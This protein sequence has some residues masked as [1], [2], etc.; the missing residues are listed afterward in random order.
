MHAYY[1]ETINVCNKAKLDNPNG[2]FNCY[3]HW[4]FAL[5][6]KGE[7]AKAVKKIKKAISTDPSDADNWVV[8]GLILRTVG[9]IDSARHKFETALK[10][11][12]ENETAI[13]EL[14]VLSKIEVLNSTIDSDQVPAIKAMV[15]RQKGEPLG[16]DRKKSVCKVVCGAVCTTF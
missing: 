15:A 4:A 16:P 10:I 14:D 3:R 12:P 5:Y 2:A 11:D 1:P 6:K 9:I 7:L 13:F 8:W